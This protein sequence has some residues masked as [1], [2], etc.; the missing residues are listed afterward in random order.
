MQGESRK[1]D[2]QS[3]RPLEV[4]SLPKAE[5]FEIVYKISDFSFPCFRPDEPWLV[6]VR[7]IR[8]DDARAITAAAL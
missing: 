7:E 8:G 5:R 3:V 2:Q 1:N 6:E 4:R